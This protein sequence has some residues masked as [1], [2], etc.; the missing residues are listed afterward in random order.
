M[1]CGASLLLGGLTISSHHGVLVDAAV[2]RSGGLRGDL[3]LI[4][5]DFQLVI[6][7]ILIF[8]L[9]IVNNIY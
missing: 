1:L 3:C 2:L 4:M 7:T 6:E 9:L 5:D 8:S